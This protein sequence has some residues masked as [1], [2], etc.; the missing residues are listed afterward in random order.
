MNQ[1]TLH[2]LVDLRD[3]GMALVRA[4]CESADNP[5]EILPPSDRREDVLLVMQ[6]T[7]R[8]TLGAIAYDTGGVLIDSGWLR[9][10]GSGHPKLTRTLSDWNCERGRGFCL[11]ADDAVGGFFAINGGAFG[12]D[13]QNIYYWPPDRLEWEPLRLGLTDFLRWSLTSRLADFYQPLRWSTWK[14]DLACLPGD[15]CFSFYPFLWTRE[16]SIDR[17]DRRPVPAAEAFDLKLAL[18]RELQQ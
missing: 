5:C 16:G 3:P 14:N 15:Q 18:T 6:V 4:W 12:D 8:S 2:E 11:V 1:R 13:V 9:F 7:T 17:S 10:L